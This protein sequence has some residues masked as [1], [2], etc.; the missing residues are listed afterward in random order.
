MSVRSSLTA[1][2]SPSSWCVC[3]DSDPAP[4]L[5]AADGY[6]LGRVAH[7]DLDAGRDRV[8]RARRRS[9]R[10]RAPRV[11]TAAFSSIVVGT[12]GSET[13]SEAV[14]RAIALAADLGASL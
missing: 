10:R 5:P 4:I 8:L 13:A 12:D 2:G 11:M 6:A 3:R 9:D 7:V 1:G 14:R